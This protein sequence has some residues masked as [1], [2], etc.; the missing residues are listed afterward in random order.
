MP[1]RIVIAGGGAAGFFAAI[2]AAEADPRARVDLLEK[3][4]ELLSKVSISGGG[5]CNVTHHCFDVERLVQNYPRGARELIGP[6]HR[7][8]PRDTVNW[9]ES[10]GVPLKV[11]SD[12]RMFPASDRSASIVQCLLGA[13]REAGVHIH[14]AR[15]LR[16]IRPRAGG[17]FDLDL[18]TGETIS[19]DRLLLATGGNKATAGYRLA[20]SVGHTIVPPVP[21]LF[22]FNVPD[23]SLHALAGIAAANARLRAPREGLEQ[24][25]PLLI[26]HWGL[27]GPAA[28]KLSA[29]G[30]RAFAECDYRT[31]IVVEWHRDSASA[32]K[33]HIARHKVRHP[34]RSVSSARAIDVPARLWEWIVRRAEIPPD[35]Q[36]GQLSKAEGGRLLE[37][38]TACRMAMDG[39]SMYK[40]EFVTC[41][42][43]R[44]SEVDFRT[45]ESRR[46]PGL[47]LAGELL[48]IDAVTGGFNFQAAWTTG[49]IAGRAMAG[50]VD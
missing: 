7:F 10:R 48:D 42:G 28:L 8:Q 1:K 6:F 21:S 31:E 34:A 19:A 3:S 30:A 15:G 14:V 23:E 17:G 44:L 35:R 25:G 36:W 9:F 40:D 22:T 49:W 24:S 50:A 16:A 29:W 32:I 33:E 47:Y 46:C 45:M 12:G 5:R 43:V 20:A 13:A 39:K 27:S 4:P 11:E 37:A 38:C 41:G 18:T 26:T 2:A